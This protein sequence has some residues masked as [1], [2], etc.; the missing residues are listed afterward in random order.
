MTT[1]KMPLILEGS[2]AG[3]A[4]GE[5]M[6]VDLDDVDDLFGDGGTLALPPRPLSRRLRQRLDELR[7]RGCRQGIAWSKGGTIASIAPDGESLQLRYL[8]ASPKDANWALSEP[9]TIAPW[10]NLAGGPLVHLS[11]SPANS[12][13]AA[14]DSVGRVFLMSFNSD[15]NRP[16][17]IRKWDADPIDELHLVV[18][19]YWLNPIPSNTRFHPIYAPA[20]KGDKGNEY[21]FEHSGLPSMGPSHPNPNK[22][23]LVCI[24]TNGLLKM[25]WSQNTGKIEQETLSLE[26][27]TS[28]DG[29]ITHAAVCSDKTKSIFIAMATTSKQLRV[30]QVGIN[31][32]IPKA[33]NGQSMPPGGY[34]ITPT[35]MKRHVAVTSW[36]QTHASESHLD[37]SMTNIS[38]IEMLPSFFNFPAKEWSPMVVLTVRSFV[39]EPNSPYNHEVQSIIDRWEL[40]TDHK[41]TLHPAFEQLGTRRNSVGSAPPAAARLKKLD[42]IVVNKVVM[43]V[44]VLSF[45]KVVCFT[46]NDGTVEYRDRF[47]MNELYREPNLDRIHSILEAGF[48]QEGEPFCLQMAFSPSNFSLVQMNEDGQVKWHNLK[49]TLTDISSISDAQLA[50]VDAAFVITTAA[51]AANGANTDD[52]LALARKFVHKDQFAVSWITEMVHITR[53]TID[54]S[55][56]IP[57]DHLIRNNTLQQCFSILNHLG[58]NGEFQ[59]RHLRSKLAMV[60]LNL[61]NIVILVSLSSNSQ[62]ATK[63][64]PSPLDEPEVV[65]ALAGCV[66]WSVDLLGWLCDSLFCLLDDTK[67]MSFLNQSNQSQQLDYMT[68]YLHSQREVALHLV[69]CS[70]TRNLISAICRRICSL[71]HYSTRAINWYTSKNDLNNLHNHNSNHFALY[72]AYRKIKQYTSSAL[73]KADEFD[74]FLTTLAVDIRSAYS[75]SLMP[76]AE[77]EA[78]KAAKNTQLS[79]QNPNAQKPDRVKEARQHCELN[80]LLGKAPPP[81]FLPVLTKLFRKD[82]T[83]F[84]ART[85]VAKLYFSNFDLLEIDDQPRVLASRRARGMRVDFFKRVEISKGNQAAPWRRCTRC[86]NV[87]EDLSTISNKPGLLFLL[88]QQRTCC[89][90]GRLALQP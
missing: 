79:N 87:M 89:C 13:L 15:L 4:G 80:L 72:A 8:R 24:T 6:Q 2:M 47:T 51:A 52:I 48:S 30:V 28:A 5:P 19:T 84:K 29:L 34:P 73:I 41:Q 7:S 42:S 10:N 45:G 35:L 71:D 14:I 65:N 75:Q 81:S 60:A 64:Q 50:A 11:W 18:G 56:E 59:P 66:K 22:S 33:E 88:S 9:K 69:L 31:F 32:N 54:Y 3:M 90:G 70:A 46:Y 58:W 36:F 74:N 1:N 27:V 62:N 49:Y 68:T 63:G 78:Q 86:S 25:F 38:H 82:L 20:V 83:E 76:L 12:E 57:H 67:F 26:S 85:D 21:T 61:R 39:P 43:G 55:E 23:A 44:N 17:T 16:S 77:R 37:A 53:I 40:L